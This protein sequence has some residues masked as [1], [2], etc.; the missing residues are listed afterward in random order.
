M[1]NTSANNRYIELENSATNS[2]SVLVPFASKS[3]NVRSSERGNDKQF[4]YSYFEKYHAIL[5]TFKSSGKSSVLENIVGRD[6]LPRGKDIV[7]RRP[8]VL[9][10]KNVP[11]DDVNGR[12]VNGKESNFWVKLMANFYA[13]VFMS[14]ILMVRVLDFF[15]NFE[16]KLSFPSVCN[17]HYSRDIDYLR[18]LRQL[19]YQPFSQKVRNFQKQVVN[20][21]QKSPA[22]V[23]IRQLPEDT[24]GMGKTSLLT[25]TG[26]PLV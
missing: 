15:I 26:Y 12:Q 1:T 10:L 9:Q 11:L 22:T 13:L 7:T 24:I 2:F 17:F 16:I 3:P 25:S 6:F 8:L 20:S 14:Q 21:I 18:Q 4:L 23:S 19:R 5:S